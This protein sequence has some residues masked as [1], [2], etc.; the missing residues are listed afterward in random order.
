MGYQAEAE[1]QVE[2][3]LAAG[4][5]KL[6]SDKGK[7][8]RAS[9]VHGNRASEEGWKLEYIKPIGKENTVKITK[10]EW[11]FGTEQW[12]KDTGGVCSWNES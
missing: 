9:V 4:N 5:S 7:N 12:K 3:Y 1:T 2:A 6:G 11:D 10:E 8:T